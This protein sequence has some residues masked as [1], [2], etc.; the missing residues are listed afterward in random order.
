MIRVRKVQHCIAQQHHQLLM[1]A[2]EQP[3]QRLI[4]NFRHNPFSHPLPKLR[5]RRPKLLSIAAD[6]ERGLLLS[7]VRLG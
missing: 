7:L 4:P 1:L 5:L 2:L 3:S 6:N